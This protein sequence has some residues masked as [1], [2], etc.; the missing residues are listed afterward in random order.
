MLS[1]Q[2]TLNKIT[3]YIEQLK[4]NPGTYNFE[5]RSLQDWIMIKPEYALQFLQTIVTKANKVLAV[6]EQSG[7]IDE[8]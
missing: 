3:A 4:L 1:S 6:F 8:E 5:G 7:T 2:E